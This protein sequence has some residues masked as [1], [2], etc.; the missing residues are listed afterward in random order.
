MRRSRRRF[1]VV[2]AAFAVLLAGAASSPAANTPA[3]CNGVEVTIAGTTGPDVLQGTPGND[4]ID[5]AEGDD[6]VDGGLGD[7]VICG[8]NGKDI[9]VG[10]PGDDTML[11]ENG[12]DTL[13]GDED[14][15]VLAGGDGTDRLSGNQGDD[16]LSGENGDDDLDGG[17]GIDALHGGNGPDRC[18]LGEEHTGCEN[19]VA[20]PDPLAALG[21]AEPGIVRTSSRDGVKV[22]IESNGGIQPWDVHVDVDGV[23]MRTVRDVL[24]S[25]AYDFRLPAD[26]P[27]FSKARITIPYDAGRL[28]GFP[29]DDLR[30]YTL[31]EASGL[32]VSAGAD[33]VV[34][35][36]NDTVTV[37]VEHFSVY[38]VLKLDEQGWARYW[39]SKPARCIPADDPDAPGALAID[40][41]FVLDESGSMASNDP[42]GLRKTA[43]KQV[44]DRLA[45]IS[46]LD[47]VG[48]VSFNTSARTRIPLT[49]LVVSSNVTAVK[50]AIDAVFASGGTDIGAGARRGLELLTGDAPAGRPRVM[51]LMTD[52]IGS[53]DDA[54]TTE[55]AEE[56]I[57]IHTVG[58][59]SG[60]DE[61]LL[62]RIATGT[63]G[64]YFPAPSADDLIAAFE[65]IGEVV[66][67]DGTDTDGDG[68]TDCE[69][70]NGMLST[71]GMFDEHLDPTQNE[72]FVG[73]RLVTSDPNDRDTDDDGLTDGEEMRGLGLGEPLD[74][75]DFDATIEEYAFLIEAG[76]TKY[77]I[78]RSDP[79]EPETDGDGLLDF[80]EAHGIEGA[81]GRTYRTRGDRWDTDLDGANDRLELELGT[82][83]L[84]PDAN[85]LGIPDLA[86]FTLF[87]PFEPPP[88]VSGRWDLSGGQ[89]VFVEYNRDPV[90]YAPP[91]F[92]C[93]INC[94]EI[95]AEA[96]RRPGGSWCWLPFSDCSS[97]EERARDIVRE[98]VAAQGIFDEDGRFR[99]DFTGEQA[100]A[101]CALTHAV[102]E[103][104]SEIFDDAPS[105]SEP[106]ESFDEAIAETLMSIPGGYRPKDLCGGS[107][108]RGGT[109]RLVDPATGRA[110]Y[111]GQT[112]DFARRRVEHANDPKYRDLDFEIRYRTDNYQARRG[113]EQ[114]DYNDLWGDVP[115]GE[116][117]AKGSLNGQRPMASARKD[118]DWRLELAQTFLDL[119]L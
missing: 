9:L 35:A 98:A 70:E 109:Y 87:Q 50:A 71:W 62:Q 8:G 28:D 115:F 107:N 55:A 89:A 91:E 25:P 27:A 64:R 44:V 90:G 66:R 17:S 31:D 75:R 33:Q 119:C 3:T 108:S 80:D 10:G 93:Q 5:A 51:V 106:G 20:A 78:M 11:G 83:P 53:Y 34:D 104:C 63:G 38:A 58:L 6:L 37:T 67:D 105:G 84:F 73:D 26:A 43:A 85:E 111:V 18:E 22:E 30:I 13:I 68:L 56:G 86:R 36:A 45:E 47:R 4:V 54:I 15:D 14:D 117:Q 2:L 114:R 100:V 48:V 101:E 95:R 110:R 49:S 96:E 52:G 23:A 88:V 12:V 41:V 57:V 69:E 82:D 7:D 74:L 21:E 103:D 61:A 81:D 42:Q 40:F 60:I 16:T 29:E 65:E 59:G 97:A 39:A 113:L 94:E 46:D 1:V 99:E 116:A 112:N 24:A 79:N 118:Y 77:F 19:V 76:I 92:E 32:W 72:P 102:P